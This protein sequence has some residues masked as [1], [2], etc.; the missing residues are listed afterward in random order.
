MLIKKAFVS[1]NVAGGTWDTKKQKRTTGLENIVWF[2]KGDYQ[3]PFQSYHF[4][5]NA[6]TIFRCFP[7][8]SK[9]VIG[10]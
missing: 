7:Q 4:N 6:G 2:F 3:M 1:S 10:P 8:A 5:A 9:D